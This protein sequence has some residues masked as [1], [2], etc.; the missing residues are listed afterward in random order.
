MSILDRPANEQVLIVFHEMQ[1]DG[2]DTEGM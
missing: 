1:P 2:F